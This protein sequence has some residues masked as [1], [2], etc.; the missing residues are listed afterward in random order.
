MREGKRCEGKSRRVKKRRKKEKEEAK[1]TK[2]KKRG[3]LSTNKTPVS[4]AQQS[5]DS[6]EHVHG[7]SV[8][9]VAS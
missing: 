8:L 3:D 7:C 4:T 2:E 5:N 1:K 9:R 6:H